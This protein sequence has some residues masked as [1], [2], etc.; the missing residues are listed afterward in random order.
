M[1]IQWNDDLEVAIGRPVSDRV[2]KFVWLC[3]AL[4]HPSSGLRE[5][6]AGTDDR[7][8]RNALARV[9]AQDPHEADRILR[10]LLL[11]HVPD[12]ELHWI[13]GRDRQASWL[14]RNLNNEISKLRL[15]APLLF[16][17]N[18]PLHLLGKTRAVALFDYAASVA[19]ST[20]ADL[21]ALVEALKVA[22]YGQTERD[23]LFSWLVGEDERRFLLKRLKD[24][25]IG[26]SASVAHFHKHEDLLLF[27][28]AEK[29]SDNEKLFLVEKARRTWNQRVRRERDKDRQ[30]CNFVMS[31]RIVK[32]LEQLAERNRLSR[33]EILEVIIAC[34]HQHGTYVRELLAQRSALMSGVQ[35]VGG[36]QEVRPK[37]I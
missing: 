25:E 26:A 23:R 24:E 19:C 5:W 36:D 21:R 1:A 7:A 3:L 27:F 11:A 13:T 17:A 37:R 18:V 20:A 35:G 2:L 14:C 16:E 34:E 29:L 31:K 28:D 30:Q 12:E 22:W 15:R 6:M 32:K 4:K 9:M 10:A 33:T 8:F